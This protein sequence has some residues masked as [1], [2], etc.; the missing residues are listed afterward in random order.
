MRKPL[1]SG[2]AKQAQVAG[3]IPCQVISRDRQP[4]LQQ[5]RISCRKTS[6][7]LALPYAH[8]TVLRYL[9]TNEKIGGFCQQTRT[10]EY[11]PGHKPEQVHFPA[12]R[13][14]NKITS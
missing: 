5:P 4:I 2:V 13:R 8:G 9:C 14:N 11:L 3:Q 6:Y 12:L 7:C 1:S 10:S